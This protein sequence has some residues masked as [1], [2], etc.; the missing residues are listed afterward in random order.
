MNVFYFSIM[1]IVFRILEFNCSLKK[2]CNISPQK[3]SWSSW[4]ISTYFHFT[5]SPFRTPNPLRSVS[6]PRTQIAFHPEPP[7]LSQRSKSVAYW[8][9]DSYVF[10]SFFFSSVLP[11]LTSPANRS[12]WKNSI[13]YFRPLKDRLNW[14]GWDPRAIFLDGG[15]R[16]KNCWGIEEGGTKMSSGRCS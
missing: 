2:S 9:T 11:F 12:S 16:R 7:G 8:I 1:I 3:P 14:I 5:T 15:E 13:C 10:F 6:D 4:S